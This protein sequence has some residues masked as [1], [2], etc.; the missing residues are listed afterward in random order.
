MNSWN[1]QSRIRQRVSQEEGVLRKSASL[2]AALCHPAD[3][4]VGMSSLG[5]QTIYREICSHPDAC[6][7]RAFLPD[8]PQEYRRNRIPVLSYESETPISNFPVIA[9]SI[10]YELELTG[11]FEILDLSGIPLLRAER[12]EKHPLIIAGGPLTNS[13]PIVLAP[14]IDLIVLGEGEDIIHSLLDDISAMSR[15]A[16]LSSYVG[17]KGIFIPGR[18]N[19][20]PDVAKVEDARLPAFSQIITKDTVLTSM[21]LIEPE[22]GCS[23]SCDYCVMRRTADRGMRLVPAD[24]VFSLIPENAQ[25]VGLVGAAVTDHPEITDLVGRIVASGREIGISS[26]RADRLNEEFIRMLAKGGYKTL[27]TASDGASQ[28]IRDSINRKTAERH[29][30][31]AA[32]MARDA[33]LKRLKLYEMVGLPNE[34]MEDIDELVRFSLELS[35]IV[36]LSIGISPFVAKRNT[37]LDGAPF[38]PINSVSEKLSRIRN[39]LKG[40]AEVRPSTPR[41]AWIEYMLSQCDESAGLAAMDAWK[42]GG[43]FSSWKQAFA[44][45]EAKPV[46]HDGDYDNKA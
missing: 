42:A 39:G 45:R 46:T 20:M 22:R 40:R 6:A 10:A 37:P 32:E 8:D 17:K 36:S 13:N 4:S 31:R 15:D 23:R 1:V 16:L 7:E 21:F 3:Y 44:E 30:I 33:G 24:K 9:F 28:R 11:I 5:F 43:S 41:W 26:L 25:R 34:T 18:M 29:L 35:T 27:T 12:N 2:R 38:E 14:F 19:R